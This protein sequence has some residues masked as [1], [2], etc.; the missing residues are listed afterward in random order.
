MI[1]VVDETFQMGTVLWFRPEAG[2]G[3]VKADSG[4][5][6]FFAR[7]AGVSEPA[8]GLR[9][10]VRSITDSEG[11]NRVELRLPPGGRD[12]VSL[13]A[14]ETISKKKTEGKVKAKAKASRRKAAKTASPRKRSSGP[15][16]GVVTRQKRRGEALERD[17]PVLHPKHGQGFVVMSTSSLVRVRFMPSGDE[18]SVHLSDLQVL[19]NT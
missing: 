6:F 3:V 11:E 14:P 5:Q 10:L 2:Q 17:I 1:Q 15:K 9:V 8:P 7:G 19:E 4:R 13:E 12:Y 16:K 18:R